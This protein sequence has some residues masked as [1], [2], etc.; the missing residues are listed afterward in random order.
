MPHLETL[1][2]KEVW[3]KASVT[4]VASRVSA[5]EVDTTE[6]NKA[7]VAKLLLEILREASSSYEQCHICLFDDDLRNSGNGTNNLQ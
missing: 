3:P 4:F 2:N 5:L 1:G 7:N 6:A